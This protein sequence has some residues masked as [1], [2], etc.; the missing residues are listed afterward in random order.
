MASGGHLGL[1]FHQVESDDERLLHLVDKKTRRGSSS[2]S[3]MPGELAS[4]ILST[5]HEFQRR[6][7]PA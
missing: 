5:R 3:W 1:C 7:R 6:K 4:A 2:R